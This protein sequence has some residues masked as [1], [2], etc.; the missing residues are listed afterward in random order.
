V[1]SR[2]RGD[3]GFLEKSRTWTW[4]WTY[5]LTNT[6]KNPVSVR[7]ERPM[8]MIVDQGVTVTY[9]DAPTSQQ[10][11]DEQMLLWNVDVPGE[12]KAEVK[13]SVTITSSKE[14]PMISDIP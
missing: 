6:H 8:P 5:V 12:G 13:H 9:N 1:N 14:I 2:R 7:L 11:P 3:S 4:A 10:V